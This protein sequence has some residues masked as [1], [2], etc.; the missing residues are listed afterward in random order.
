[1]FVAL[2]LISVRLREVRNGAVERLI[3]AKIGVPR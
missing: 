3:R 1:M 2:R